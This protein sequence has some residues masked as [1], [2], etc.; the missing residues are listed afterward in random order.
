MEIRGKEF[1]FS[2]TTYVMGVLNV[3][4]DSFSDG[5]LHNSEDGALA[6]A[7]RMVEEGAAIIDVGGESTRPGFTPVS[8]EEELSRVIPVI[9]AIRK[10]SDIPISIDTTKAEVA[11]A[12]MAAGADIINSVSGVGLSE[13]MLKAVRDNGAFFIMTYEFGYVNQF[14]RTL[15]SMAERAIDAGV[16]ARKIIVDPG[17]G[18]GKTFEENLKIVNELP[19]LTQTGYPLLLGTSRKSMIGNVL[20]GDPDE[21]LTGTLV[22]TVL[23]A[24][25]GVAIVRVHDVAENVKAIRML[26]AICEV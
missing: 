24:L 1:D 2:K 15:T 26:N 4:P 14:V 18:F 16:A 20:G 5:G 7:L 9:E 12:A 23:A 11:N 21:R 19:F 17:V 6:H 13:D 3:T 25:A 10:E 22:T 8:A